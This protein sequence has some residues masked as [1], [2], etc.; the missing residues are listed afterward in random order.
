MVVDLGVSEEAALF[1]ELDKV[2][3]AS[4]ASFGVLGP[5]L[6]AQ[7]QRAF[8]VAVAARPAG[9][10]QFEELLRLKLE[11]GLELLFLLLGKECRFLRF[12]L[13]QRGELLRFRLFARGELLRLGFLACEA[14]ALPLLFP[15]SLEA[16]SF[17]CDPLA[18]PLQLDGLARALPLLRGLKPR[19]LL[20]LR[21]FHPG[22][23]HGVAGPVLVPRRLR[24]R[25]FLRFLPAKP[26]FFL[27]SLGARELLRFAC[28]QALFL[29]PQPLRSLGFL[30]L[31]PCQGFCASF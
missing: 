9:P 14:L 5:G 3:Q 12:R 11:L 16:Q 29:P 10:A 27:G 18:P 4:A 21:G 6:R 8:G 15:G 28:S 24:S 20:V 31:E 23:I 1:S 22:R 30:R 7:Q 19:T 26:F 17:L 13:L 25:R 2:L